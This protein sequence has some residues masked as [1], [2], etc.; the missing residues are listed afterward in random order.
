L[1]KETII[2]VDDDDLIQSF[3]IYMPIQELQCQ[4]RAEHIVDTGNYMKEKNKIAT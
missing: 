4:L 3:I 2:S 1:K